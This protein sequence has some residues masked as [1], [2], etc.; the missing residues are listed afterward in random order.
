MDYQETKAFFTPD[1]SSS[2]GSSARSTGRF[3][4]N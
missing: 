4:N 3:R 1:S 2:E